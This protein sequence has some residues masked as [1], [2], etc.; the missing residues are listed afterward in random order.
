MYHLYLDIKFLYKIGLK[1]FIR[2]KKAVKVQDV[3]VL[4]ELGV[5]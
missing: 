1:D 5:Y 2:Y 3:K 4:K